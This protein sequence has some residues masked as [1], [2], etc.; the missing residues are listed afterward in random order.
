MEVSAV[1]E[2]YDGKSGGSQSRRQT[3]GLRVGSAL[4]REKSRSA[5]RSSLTPCSMQSAAMR[6]S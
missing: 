3:S 5:E 6:A 2:R 1:R 4:K